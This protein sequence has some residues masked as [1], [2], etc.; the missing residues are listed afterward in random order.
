M[1]PATTSVPDAGNQPP[2]GDVKPQ[3]RANRW[4]IQVGV[5][6]TESEA[7]IRIQAVRKLV[8]DLLG[9]S[10]AYTE[11]VLAKDN[12]T[13]L[14]ARFGGLDRARAE[15]VCRRLKRADVSC[16][17]VKPPAGASPA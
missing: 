17:T 12:R 13:L 6:D 10:G 5:F 16:L 7:Q 1:A 9:S 3:D 2:N 8:P 4:I 15:E 11:S 14:R